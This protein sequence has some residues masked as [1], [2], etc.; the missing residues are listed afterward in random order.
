MSRTG[1][2]GANE[3]LQGAAYSDA[4]SIRQRPAPPK[5]KRHRVLHAVGDHA[6]LVFVAAIFMMPMVFIVLTSLM[7]DA[8]SLSPSIW[9]RPFVWHNYVTIFTEVPLLRYTWTFLYIFF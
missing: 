4:L 7:T 1:G 5:A 3:A 9:P 2:A 8:Q 6:L